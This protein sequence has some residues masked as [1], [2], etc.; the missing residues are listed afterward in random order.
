[1]AALVPPILGAAA[2]T[3][4]GIA[5]FFISEA[6]TIS[7]FAASLASMIGLAVAVDYSLFI[8][9]RYREELAAG[10]SHEDGL[11]R[12]LSTSAVAVTFSRVTVMASLAGLFLM[13]N[14]TVRSMALGAIIVVGVAILGATTLLPALIV[15]LGR[16]VEQP[17][18]VGHAISRLAALRHHDDTFWERRTRRMTR[19][20]RATVVATIGLLLLLAYPLSHIDPNTNSTVELNSGAPARVGANEQ[21]KIDG[22]GS[23]APT[24]VLVRFDNGTASGSANQQALAEVKKTLT[25]EGVAS[26]SQP[27]PSQ[28]QTDALFEVVL[29]NS[30]ESMQ[31]KDTVKQLRK[32]LAAS[33]AAKAATISVGGETAAEIDFDKSI[34][35]SMWKIVVFII[36]VAFVILTT[37]LRSILLPVIGVVMNVL[38]VAAA[39]GV[40]VVVF[41]WGWLPFLGFQDLGFVDSI[42]LPLLL[43]V[44]FGLSTDYRVFL[45]TRVRERRQQGVAS[46][47]AAIE[48]TAISARTITSAACIMI[49]VFVV[50]VV[51]GVP[52]IQAAGLGAAVAVAASALLVQ[53]AFMPSVIILLGDRVWWLPRWLDR[54]LPEVGVE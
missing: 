43:A 8:L 47:D 33:S 4:T 18:L 40:L 20:P 26:V 36:V 51:L 41:Q 50:F 13:P 7:I 39:Y 29:T 3:I 54:L 21:A 52:T 1:M 46:R 9:M 14:S 2:I 17:A 25:T 53:L 32:D 30:P 49:G 37:L 19:Y 27:D 31:A 12:A 34:V 45:L 15:V 23:T 42:I 22:A 6:L 48:A 16:T 5:I 24:L 11:A 10:A 35:S 28:N 38:C 44:V